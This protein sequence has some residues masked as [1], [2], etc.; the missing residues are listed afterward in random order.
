MLEKEG[1]TYV[2]KYIIRNFFCFL[3]MKNTLIEFEEMHFLDARKVL[4]GFEIIK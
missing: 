1:T 4:L 3:E 2:S